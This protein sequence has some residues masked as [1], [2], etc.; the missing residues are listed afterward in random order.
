[1]MMI[2]IIAPHLLYITL[3]EDEDDDHNNNNNND[4]DNDNCPSPLIHLAL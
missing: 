1:M 4:D 3:C 2:M